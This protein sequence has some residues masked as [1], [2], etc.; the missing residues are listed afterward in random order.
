ME[1]KVVAA[2]VNRDD[3]VET[4]QLGCRRLINLEAVF[5][6]FVFRLFFCV[7]VCTY[8]VKFAE[9]RLK[10]SR[11]EDAKCARGER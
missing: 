3:P 2:V 10:K 4:N 11:K 9:D 6:F 7:V 8:K 1:K 5:S